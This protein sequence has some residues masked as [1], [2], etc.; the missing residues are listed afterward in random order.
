MKRKNSRSIDYLKKGILLTVFTSP[1]HSQVTNKTFRKHPEHR[2]R[3]IERRI[4]ASPH[5]H[6]SWRKIKIKTT[7]TEPLCVNSSNMGFS[8]YLQVAI[9]EEE[10]HPSTLISHK[11]SN[12][13]QSSKTSRNQKQQKRNSLCEDSSQ[14]R[15]DLLSLFPLIFFSVQS[16]AFC[17]LS[18]TKGSGSSHSFY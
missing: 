10:R 15:N 6:P 12:P 8:H 3:K 13:N 18:P 16:L 9:P 17:S 11:N 4:F 5:I 2:I 1:Y 7:Q 14:F